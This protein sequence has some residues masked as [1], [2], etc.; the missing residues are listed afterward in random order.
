MRD[1]DKLARVRLH[2]GTVVEVSEWKGRPYPRLYGTASADTNS[3]KNFLVERA[4]TSFLQ[5]SVA[6]QLVNGGFDGKPT[7]GVSVTL[8]RPWTTALSED[9]KMELQVSCDI[10]I[11]QTM[12]AYGHLT[13]NRSTL[14]AMLMDCPFYLDILRAT[15]LGEPFDRGTPTEDMR[16]MLVLMASEHIDSPDYIGYLLDSLLQGKQFNQALAT[17]QRQ[18]HFQARAHVKKLV[19]D[20]RLASRYKVA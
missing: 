18:I 17:A 13:D 15:I 16:G 5:S 9:G 8:R 4:M 12:T 19:A 20:M 3:M 11:T 14:H 6:D 2:S 10:G 1:N 7:C